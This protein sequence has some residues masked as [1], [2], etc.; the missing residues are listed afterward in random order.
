MM[1]D[2]IEGGAAPALAAHSK[3]ASVPGKSPAS[4]A[5]ETAATKAGRAAPGYPDRPDENGRGAGG[6]A[7][8]TGERFR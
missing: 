5:K 3:D 8:N 1:S 7:V 4:A 2:K 6:G